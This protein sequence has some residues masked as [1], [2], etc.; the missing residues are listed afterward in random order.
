MKTQHT[1]GPWTVALGSWIVSDKSQIARAFEANPAMGF[2][3]NV[4]E[5]EK[6]ANARL[7]AAAPELLALVDEM[8]AA[9][10]VLAEDVA[11]TFPA[12]SEAACDLAMKARDAIAKATGAA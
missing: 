9:L 7:I 1:P 11:D 3:G 6:D 8:Q 12:R 10:D 4:T 2:P 5:Q